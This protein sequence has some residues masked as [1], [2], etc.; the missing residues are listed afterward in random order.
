VHALDVGPAGSFDAASVSRPTVLVDTDL[1]HLWY[2]G[3]DGATWRIGHAVGSC[4]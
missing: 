1:W 4:P 3:F 2:G